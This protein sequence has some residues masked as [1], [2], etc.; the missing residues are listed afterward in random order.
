MRIR[1]K[2]IQVN[3]KDYAK[4]EYTPFFKGDKACPEYPTS[5]KLGDVVVIKEKDE[6]E[7]KD[8]LR[9]GVVLGCIDEECEELRTDMS[10]MVCYQDIEPYHPVKHK[11]VELPS[12][13]KA[14]LIRR[15]YIK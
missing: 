7:E 2:T 9:V 14:D 13:L 15:G 12:N 8:V 6:N 3:D 10:G 11:D 5:Y 1:K 4:F